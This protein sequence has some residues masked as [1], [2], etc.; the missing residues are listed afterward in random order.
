MSA[1]WDVL[2]DESFAVVDKLKADKVNTTHIHYLRA[3]HGFFPFP[4]IGTGTDA[5]H[6][7]IQFVRAE[8]AGDAHAVPTSQETIREKDLQED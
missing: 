6:E 3:T 5:C 2:R 8:T 7:F 4:T 1:E